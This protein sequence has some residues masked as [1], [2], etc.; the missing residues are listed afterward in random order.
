MHRLIG[1]G[2]RLQAVGNDG[3]A[4]QPAARAFHDDPLPGRDRLGR[5]QFVAQLD[6]HPWL[7]LQIPGHDAGNHVKVLGH[8]VGRTHDRK[9]GVRSGRQVNRGCVAQDRRPDLRAQRVLRD[10]AFERFIVLWKRSV[11]EMGGEDLTETAREHDKRVAPLVIGTAIRMHQRHSSAI[12]DVTGPFSAHKPA[13]FDLPFESNDPARPIPGPPA[14]VDGG[15]IVDNPPIQGPGPGKIGVVADLA[16]WVVLALPCGLIARLGVAV[17]VKPVP[18]GGSAVVPQE[19]KTG[20]QGALFI[21]RA[22]DGHRFD[23]IAVDHFGHFVSI[24]Q[25]IGGVVPF[26]VAD[27]FR[28]CAAVRIACFQ[29]AA[30]GHQDLAVGSALA[31]RCRTGIAPLHPA[32]AVGGAALF[33]ERGASRQAEDLGFDLFGRH[34]RTVPEGT[35][36]G[37]EC[38]DVHHPVQSRQAL[39]NDSDIAAGGGRV[40]PPGEKAVDVTVPHGVKKLPP[41]IAAVVVAFGQPLVP[42]VIC[43]CGRVCEHGFQ[44]TDRI[45]G[46]VAPPVGGARFG[47]RG[48]VVAMVGRQIGVGFARHAQIAG[49]AAEQ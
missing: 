11:S 40:H 35:G 34:A 32:A 9:T 21:G 24:E 10:W 37:V 18:A 5:G 25:A 27:R 39:A 33:F 29:L 2:Q 26:E 1:N 7:Q 14:G 28:K 22:V 16:G 44:E 23:K 49:P 36:L 6:E 3:G 47:A 48:R 12:D 17:A 15:A 13:A 45:S 38:V 42:E 8:S 46:K 30:Q 41:R 4:L 31:Q 20:H 43:G 19:Y